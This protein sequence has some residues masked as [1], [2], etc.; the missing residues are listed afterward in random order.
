MMGQPIEEPV[1]ANEDREDALTEDLVNL[2][3]ISLRDHVRR[4][5]LDVMCHTPVIHSTTTIVICSDTTVMYR[6]HC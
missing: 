6:A 1:E 2:W 5:A 4:E 3:D